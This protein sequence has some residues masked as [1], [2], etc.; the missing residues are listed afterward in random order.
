MMQGTM[1]LKKNSRKSCRLWDNVEK[2]GTVGQATD[3][4][5]AHARCMVGTWRY[6]YAHSDYVMLIAF[7]PAKIVTWRRLSVFAY[8]SLPP[9]TEKPDTLGVTW[10][11]NLRHPVPKS[12]FVF[13]A[14]R[15]PRSGCC[16]CSEIRS[17]SHGLI[18]GEYGGYC[19]TCHLRSCRT[20]CTVSAGQACGVLISKEFLTARHRWLL[21]N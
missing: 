17:H 14:R 20:Y 18:S 1:S 13:S 12:K 19:N 8:Y 7:S 11:A 15:I 5:V 4:N 2:Y 10:L 21:Q 3:E 9:S 6:K 16:F